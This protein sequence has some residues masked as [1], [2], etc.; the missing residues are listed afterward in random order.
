METTMTSESETIF[1]KIESARRPED[2]FGPLSGSAEQR[3]KG[4]DARHHEVVIKI[5]PD[6]NAGSTRSKEAFQRF[7]DLVEQAKAAIKADTYG[8]SGVVTITTKQHTY[9]VGDALDPM[10][11]AHCYQCLADG[12]THGV[13]T[14]AQTPAD[15]DLLQTEAKMLQLLTS[16]NRTEAK[17][18]LPML[19]KLTETFRYTEGGGIERQANVY[20]TTPGFVSIK[21]IQEAYPAGVGPKHLN[22]IWRRLLDVLGYAHSRGVIHGAVLPTNVLIGLDD[23]HDVVLTNWQAAVLVDG[24]S[25]AHISVMDQTYKE[26][27]PPEVPKKLTPTYGTDLMMSARCM[28]AMVGGNPVSGMLPPAI[29][30]RIAGFL[31]SCLLIPPSQRPQSAWQLRREF[32]T[33]MDQLGKREYHPLSLPK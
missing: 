19:P 1:Q 14:V 12:I 23:H 31:Q 33:A 25:T 22:W 28:I 17:G 30:P 7:Q 24:G 32:T 5:H 2:F 16:P 29:H 6:L 4:V 20:T 26:W 9:S 3:E 11:A 21:Q 18:Y 13:F 15:N 10:G 27:Y 8:H